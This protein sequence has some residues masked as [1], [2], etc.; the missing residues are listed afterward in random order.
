MTMR[1]PEGALGW[2]SAI[3]FLFGTLSGALLLAQGSTFS[4]VFGLLSA[5]VAVLAA[6]LWLGWLWVRIPFTLYWILI[7]VVGVVLLFVAPVSIKS[8]GQVPL[9]LFFAYL[10]FNWDP[11]EP[12][13]ILLDLRGIHDPKDPP[14]SAGA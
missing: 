11:Q 4:V 5:G 8:V 7:A 2:F 9:A 6:G 10:V 1:K 13:M 14:R 3:W 12:D